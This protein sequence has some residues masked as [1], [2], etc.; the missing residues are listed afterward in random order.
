[1]TARSSRR[2]RGVVV[3]VHGA[4]GFIDIT[5]SLSLTSHTA[6]SYFS[7]LAGCKGTFHRLRNSLMN[8]SPRAFER[9]R[10][11]EAKTSGRCRCGEVKIQLMGGAARAE[12]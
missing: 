12:H 9:R 7:G 6:L 5:A 2:A 4:G 1:M 8:H 11:H 3:A 10:G